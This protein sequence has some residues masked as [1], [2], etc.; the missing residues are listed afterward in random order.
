M[1]PVNNVLAM[2]GFRNCRIYQLTAFGIPA[3][4]NTTP[5]EGTRLSGATALQ[6]THPAP[7]DIVH[8][9]D[10]YIFARDIL[11]PNAALDAVL[12]A[13]K[14]RNDIDAMVSGVKSYAIGEAAG[15]NVATD[16]Q[17]FEPQFGILGY[18]QAEDAN[19]AGTTMGL[20]QWGSVIFP[21]AWIIFQEQARDQNPY[22]SQYT[23]RAAL[24]TAHLWGLPYS[25]ATEGS[26]IAQEERYAT[27]YKPNIAA[28]KVTGT[29]P[30]ALLFATARQAVSTAKIAVVTNCTTAGVITDVTS[31][32]T[33]ATTGIT[34]ASQADGDIFVA[35]YEY[36]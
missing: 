10:D 8:L 36:A 31:S 3:A 35:Y 27:Q 4:T 13:G 28:W 7:R 29:S 32:V 18:S 11:P 15:M 1:T 2:V 26:L 6:I 25:I 19:E 12:R 16:Q 34:P 5:Y 23:V 33:K 22:S 20:R 30:A 17:G 21:K 14:V 24:G 9:G